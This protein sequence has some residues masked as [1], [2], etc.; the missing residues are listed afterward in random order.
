LRPS[1]LVGGALAGAPLRLRRECLALRACALHR[2]V[3]GRE[4]GA[5]LVEIRLRGGA[6]HVG[7]T[8]TPAEKQRGEQERDSS[9]RRAISR[10]RT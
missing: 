6:R 1:F 9:A 5:K 8:R 3:D 4:I 10:S 2:L 7:D